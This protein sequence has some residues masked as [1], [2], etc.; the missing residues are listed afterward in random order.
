MTARTTVMHKVINNVTSQR[1][2]S[3]HIALPYI[4][5]VPSLNVRREEIPSM[6]AQR[7]GN[8]TSIRVSKDVSVPVKM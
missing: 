7:V 2:R 8:P 1:I 6:T 3:H 4:E 5:R